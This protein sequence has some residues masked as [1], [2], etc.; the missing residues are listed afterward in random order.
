M[1]VEHR[2]R[3]WVMFAWLGAAAC[4]AGMQRAAS[5]AMMDATAV[6]EAGPGMG[7]PEGPLQLIAPP[8]AVTA[9]GEPVDAATLNARKSGDWAVV[10]EF[11]VAT[12]DP[13]DDGPRQDFRETIFW[14][15]NVR[16][17]PDGK[18][19][20][21][22]PTS[23]AITSFRVIAEGMVNGVAGHAETTIASRL[24]ISIA[25]NLP[26]EVTTGDRITLPVTITNTTGKAVDAA[27]RATAGAAIAIIE[28][29]DR[30]VRIPAHDARTVS[31]ELEITGVDGTKGAG[32]LAFSVDGGSAH[33]ELKRSLAIVPNGFPASTQMAGTVDGTVKHTVSIP[34]SAVAG[35]VHTT[36]K[37]YPSPVATMTAAVDSIVRE[38]SGCFEQAS[39][40]NYP[41]VMV[42]SYLKAA[43]AQSPDVE[44]QAKAAL[45]HGYQ[46]LTGYESASHGFEWFGA[47]PGHE[48]LSA[49]GLLQFQRMAK[50][51]DVDATMLDR[52]AAWLRARRDGKGGYQRNQNALH[53]FGQVNTDV[54]NAYITYALA[55]A[56]QKDLEVELAY[57]RDV[58]K[59][60]KDPYILALSAAAL[61][62]ADPKDAAGLAALAVL[63]KRQ[64]A[65]G[66]WGGAAQSIM[67][68][69]GE[70]LAI[71]TTAFATLA[72]LK[73]PASYRKE[74]AAATAW[75]TAQRSQWGGFSSTQATVLALEVLTQQAENSKVPAGATISVLVDGK[76]LGTAS[77][78]GADGAIDLV[79]LGAHLS[80]G[81]HAIELRTSKGARLDYSLGVRWYDAAPQSSSKAAVRV[82]TTIDRG[83]LRA[84]RPVRL[85]ATIENVTTKGQPMTL[86]RIGIPGGLRYQPWQLDELVDK[87][88]VDFVETR[89]REVILY[90]RGM[91][92][93]EKRQVPIELLAQVPGH[94]V[95]PPSSAYLYYT[96]EHRH[97][98]QPLAVDVK[99]PV[100][101]AKK[102][103]VAS[104][105][106]IPTPVK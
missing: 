89:E 24:P 26:V 70:A 86:A 52:T 60:T 51:Y 72:L 45:A 16:T 83:K 91:K 19:R 57:A 94:Y 59:Q 80:A 97:Y 31:F 98:A 82:A 25:A 81:E 90:L 50:V 8:P 58:T 100:K 79:D 74:I 103:P 75:I 77:L 92:A 64:D 67:V 12:Y 49:Y 23:D 9:G 43:G 56:G 48:G 28:T 99:R 5:P 32:E 84:G 22:F 27:I 87:Q 6:A 34:A 53:N 21:E 36:I 65:D 47:D 102:K 101:K 68:S 85:T 7:M 61:L 55:E 15:P 76:E 88:V 54:M 37:L 42:L 96:D 17:G 95:A 40:A 2:S 35:S 78:E 93:K 33:D 18:A 62:A 73:A 105:T 66:H 44:S 106:A 14:A 1:Q 30:T 29:A 13:A 41:N 3:S 11:A 38:P 71:E 69:G 46:L 104:A 4:G 20:I 63:A 10:R 39:S